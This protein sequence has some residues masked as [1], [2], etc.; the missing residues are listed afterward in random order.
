MNWIKDRIKLGVSG[1]LARIAKAFY[2]QKKFTGAAAVV[3]HGHVI[4][5]RSFGTANHARRM[6][7]K[8]DTVFR[9]GSL[10]KPFTALLIMKLI[11]QGRFALDTSVRRW[12]PTYP[13]AGRITIAHLL[14]NRS[15]I[16]DL[17]PMPEYAAMMGMPQT[18]AALIKLFHD[19]PLQYEPG[20][21]FGYSNSNWIMLGAIFEAETGI[22]YAEGLH[23]WIFSPLG[24]SRS[25][26]NWEAVSGGRAVGYNL[27]NPSSDVYTPAL[28]IHSTAMGAAGAIATTLDDMIRWSEGVFSGRV[29]HLETLAQMIPE[30]DEGYGLG[31]EIHTVGTVKTVGHSGGIDGFI[32]NYAYAPAEG[33][34]VIILSN[35]GS[36]AIKEMLETLLLAALKKPFALP[37]K[38]TFISLDPERLAPFVGAYDVEFFGRVFR[39]NFSI[40]DGSLVMETS[41]LSSTVLRPITETTFFGRSKGE[42][43]MTFSGSI[44]GRADTIQMRWAGYDGTAHRVT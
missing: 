9:I 25:T 36:A 6:P 12:F 37:E 4:F 19:A 41:G 8:A 26:A 10:T 31:W 39:L 14:G 38:R 20:N 27:S 43:E 32:S 33:I 35:L 13:H 34:A 18:N 3:Q 42:V 15:G 5:K 40:C 1:D 7:N 16:P 24:M 22:T 21:A 30:T 44:P 2:T 28:P 11:E 17:I 23:Q 29:I